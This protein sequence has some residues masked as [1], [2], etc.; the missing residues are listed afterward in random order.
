MRISTIAAS[1][2]LAI[3]ATPL[4]AAP[5]VDQADQF[6]SSLGAGFFSY[7]GVKIMQT[8]TVGTS[9]VMTR[10]DIPLFRED[11][12]LDQ[13]AGINIYAIAAGLPTSIVAKGTVHAVS[14]DNAYFDLGMAVTAG[15]MLALE[16]IFISGNS[17]WKADVANHY[18]RGMTVVDIAGKWYTAPDQDRN[19]VTYVDPDAVPAPVPEA[20]TW[21]L[22]V[23]GFGM[24][25][26]AVRR[27][28]KALARLA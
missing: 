26:A 11:F 14:L 8:F 27:R 24:I 4:L 12:T 22:L 16:P 7:P 9:G 2:V 1:L 19:F 21:S 6:N 20:S 18:S 10:I 15:Q 28:N 23:G 5:K 17:L 25:G 3:G 13:F